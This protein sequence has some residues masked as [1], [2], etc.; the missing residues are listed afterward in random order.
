MMCS[1]LSSGTYSAERCLSL[2]EASRLPDTYKCQHSSAGAQ[3]TGPASGLW[4]SIPCSRLILTFLF[5]VLS[6]LSHLHFL[7]SYTQVILLSSSVKYFHVL[8]WFCIVFCVFS[9]FNLYKTT[10]FPESLSSCW[11]GGTSLLPQVFSIGTV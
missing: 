1:D 7:C 5:T 11:K 9:L 10:L 8:S 6:Q 3:L 4:F 2:G